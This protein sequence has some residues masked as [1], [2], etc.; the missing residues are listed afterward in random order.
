MPSPSVNSWYSDPITS[1]FS[2]PKFAACI[3]DL[4][5]IHIIYEVI[6]NN[7]TTIHEDDYHEDNSNDTG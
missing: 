5:A 4:G 1:D 3:I 6:A 2:D 7:T